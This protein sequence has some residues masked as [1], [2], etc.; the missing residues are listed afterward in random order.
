MHKTLITDL[1]LQYIMYFLHFTIY[2]IHMYIYFV[3]LKLTKKTL[4]GVAVMH[5]SEGV[6][7]VYFHLYVLGILNLC[8]L[9]AVDIF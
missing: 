3:K 8:K 1:I 4:L 7:D 6:M 5:L 9:F 2:I